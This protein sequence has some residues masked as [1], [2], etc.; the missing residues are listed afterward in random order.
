[1]PQFT[2][3]LINDLIIK[4][5]EFMK[6]E[7]AKNQITVQN[8]LNSDL[9][10]MNMDQNLLYRVFLNLFINAIQAM[11]DGGT[12]SISTSLSAEEKKKIVIMIKDTGVGISKEK[13]AMVFTPFY[14]DKNRGTGLGLAIAKNIIEEHSG[15]IAV[16]SKIGKGTT[17]I[18]TLVQQ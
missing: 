12:L 14:T 17:F 1:V 4:V 9:K 5:E 15:S 18:I 2:K 11:P 6:P 8:D 3:G 10:P 16:E 13:L 7:F